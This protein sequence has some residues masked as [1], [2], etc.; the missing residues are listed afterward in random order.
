MSNQETPNHTHSLLMESRTLE[1]KN[2]S[3]MVQILD[4]FKNKFDQKEYEDMYDIILP[5]FMN[6]LK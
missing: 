1:I 4:Q 2:L 5:E 6:K 3:T